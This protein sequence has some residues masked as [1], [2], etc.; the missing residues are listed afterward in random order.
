M[1]SVKTIV[2]MINVNALVTPSKLAFTK[3]LIHDLPCVNICRVSRKVFKLLP[4]DPANVNALKQTCVTVIL[5][6]Y[7]IP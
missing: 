6:F 5:A 7:M 3:Q 2:I 4:R 1:L